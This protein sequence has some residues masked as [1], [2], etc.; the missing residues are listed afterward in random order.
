MNEK[1]EE[2]RV[3]QEAVEERVR[4]L[5]FRELKRRFGFFCDRGLGRVVTK[6]SKR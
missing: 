3:Y 1:L 2:T 6:S 4:S 5:V